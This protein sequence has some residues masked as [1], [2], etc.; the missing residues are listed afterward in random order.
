MFLNINKSSLYTEATVHLTWYLYFIVFWSQNLTHIYITVSIGSSAGFRYHAGM[1]MNVTA[2]GMC[3]YTFRPE[4][5]HIYQS[6]ETPWVEMYV[7]STKWLTET[8][9]TWHMNAALRT[10]PKTLLA[11]LLLFQSH[12]IVAILGNYC[13]I[14]NHLK[15]HRKEERACAR[16]R[17]AVRLN[18]RDRDETSGFLKCATSW[19]KYN[20]ITHF[21]QL[22]SLQE[23]FPSGI[24]N[25]VSNAAENAFMLFLFGLS[26]GL[27]NPQLSYLYIVH[28]N[29][30]EKKS[31]ASTSQTATTDERENLK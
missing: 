6:W 8:Q 15:S 29:W 28:V 20:K 24:S 31:G 5:Q 26:A 16:E 13:L 4:Y 7:N 19:G 21:Y 9:S 22:F 18:G 2:A 1:F 10:I 27:L 11:K 25:C 12:W 23:P 30:N 3:E 14:F 17:E